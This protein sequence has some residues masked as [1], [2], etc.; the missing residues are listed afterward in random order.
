MPS[1]RPSPCFL[2]VT[3][4][5][6]P[7]ESEKAL[8]LPGCVKALKSPPKSNIPLLLYPPCSRFSMLLFFFLQLSSSLLLNTMCSDINLIFLAF[9][10]HDTC[11][12]TFALFPLPVY[13]SLVLFQDISFRYPFLFQSRNGGS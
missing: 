5:L 13:H 8:R 3:K 1:C 9:P 12:Q 11:T 4:T 2:Q 7:S 6:E 10:Y